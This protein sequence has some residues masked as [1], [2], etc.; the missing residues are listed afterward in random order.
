[1]A[2]SETK[3]TQKSRAIILAILNAVILILLIILI[4]IVMK[5]DTYS[6]VKKEPVIEVQTGTDT[7]PNTQTET[8]EDPLKEI[9]PEKTYGSWDLDSLS[10][11]EVPYGNNPDKTTTAGIPEGVFYYKSLWGK[12]RAEFV[13]QLAF[14]YNAG[15][16]TD[17]SIYLTF[18]CSTDSPETGKILDILKEKKVAATFFI[19]GEYYDTHKDIVSRMIKEGHRIGSMGKS[20]KS[21]TGLSLDKQKEEILDVVNK[22][23]DD[24]GYDCRLFRFP[25]WGFTEQSL[26]LVDNLGLKS[27][28]WSY[29]YTDTGTAP[30]SLEEA[31]EKAV[32]YLHPGAVY[33]M[34]ANSSVSRELLGKWIDAVYEKG[35]D[36]AGV[37]PVEA[38]E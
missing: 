35:Y 16:S 15:T 37:Y 2:K 33:S 34:R 24:Y 6:T 10:K 30:L 1:M 14:D 19:T 28:F 26:A 29:T 32:K 36:F 23:Q 7:E 22:L 18:D 12:Y 5:R 9:L 31:Y 20:G 3:R 27:V 13:S 25:T 17:K 38:F 8:E 21:L 4:V 11:E